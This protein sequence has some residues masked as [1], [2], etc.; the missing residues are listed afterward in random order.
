LKLTLT[1]GV[2][3]IIGALRIDPCWIEDALRI[4]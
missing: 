2:C 4:G 1:D 3:A